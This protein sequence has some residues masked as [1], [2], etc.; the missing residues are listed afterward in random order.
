MTLRRR[1]KLGLRCDVSQKRGFVRMFSEHVHKADI[2]AHIGGYP[3]R[4]RRSS[5]AAFAL[6]N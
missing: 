2:S 6:S 1:V 4:R 3:S 5:V